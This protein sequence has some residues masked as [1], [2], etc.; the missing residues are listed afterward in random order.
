MANPPEE[1]AFSVI[2]LVS[3]ALS[4][5]G[6]FLAAV[7]SEPVRR[8]VFG[9]RLVIEYEHSPECRLLTPLLSSP[10]R[11]AYY[12]RVRVRNVK[13]MLALSCRGYLVGVD[14]ARDGKPFA[15]TRYTDVIPLKWSYREEFGYEPLDIPV[16]VPFYLDVFSTLDGS[17]EFKPSIEVMPTRCVGEFQKP[18]TYRFIIAVS[19]DSVR[20]VVKRLLVQWKENWENFLVTPES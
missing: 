8:R 10:D 19:G 5:L 7:F 20:P 12:V 15:P 2:Q 18:G 4:F 16:G 3:S 9:P 11:K 13:P 14:W 6:G 1:A 17:S